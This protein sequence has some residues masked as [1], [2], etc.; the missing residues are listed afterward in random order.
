LKGKKLSSN[1]L[2]SPK[3]ISK[4]AFGGKIDVEKHFAQVSF[5]APLKTAQPSKP[6]K[7]VAK[8]EADAALIDDEQLAQMKELAPDLKVIWTSPP[9]PP[10]PVVAFTKNATPADKAAFAKALPKICEAKGKAV[11]D[12]MF[13][14]K[15]VPVDKVAFA[16]AAKRYDK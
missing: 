10:T 3:Y 6:I 1:H 16:E 11:C 15:F 7:S 2:A 14:E 5:S 8:G 9:L 13:I 12:S 4:V